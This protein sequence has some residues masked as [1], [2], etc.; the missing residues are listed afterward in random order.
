MLQEM[1]IK[2][3]TKTVRPIIIMVFIFLFLKTINGMCK[4]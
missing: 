2:I 1:G 3:G 4:D